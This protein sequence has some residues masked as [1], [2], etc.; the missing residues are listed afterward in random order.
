LKEKLIELTENKGYFIARFKN[1]ITSSVT[2]EFLEELIIILEL[3][4][5]KEGNNILI[6]KGSNGVFNLGGDLKMFLDVVE[7][8]ESEKLIKYALFCVKIIDI[9]K[10]S[11]KDNLFIFSLINGETRGG[12]FEAALASNFIIGIKENVMSFPETKMGFFPGM[13]GFEN[14]SLRVGIKEAKNILLSGDNFTVEEL[15]EKNIIDYVIDK[16]ENMYKIIKKIE[17]DYIKNLSILSIE[18][19]MTNITKEDLEHSVLLWVNNILNLSKLNI[20]MIKRII[21]KQ[22]N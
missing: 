10:T 8:N 3:L 21:S 6:L 22:N 2:F 15:L 17:N 12:G 7:N 16:E 19:R 14:L 4:R 20:K 11:Y 18:D 5:K 9:M 13:G 1:E